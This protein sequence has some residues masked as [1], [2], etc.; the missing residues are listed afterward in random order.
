MQ[1]LQDRW[2]KLEELFKSI[3]T[4]KRVEIAPIQQLVD[5]K[6]WDG[7]IG[8]KVPAFFVVLKTDDED[9]NSLRAESTW[10]LIIVAPSKPTK[11]TDAVLALVKECRAKLNFQ[12]PGTYLHLLPKNKLTFLQQHPQIATVELEINTTD[13]E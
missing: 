9:G 11:K 2:S 6:F 5:T 13:S 10:A 8:L 1:D 3:T 7:L 12:W 4:F